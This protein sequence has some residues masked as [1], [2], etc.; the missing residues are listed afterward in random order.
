MTANGSFIP[1][2][3]FIDPNAELAKAL[4][5]RSEERLE[6]LRPEAYAGWIEGAEEFASMC[7]ERTNADVDGRLCT[8]CCEG[9]VC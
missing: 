4:V 1:G 7:C 8:K 5:Q 3:T 2:Y 9:K 6:K